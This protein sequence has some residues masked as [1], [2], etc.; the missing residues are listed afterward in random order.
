MTLRTKFILYL[1]ILHTVFVGLSLAVFFFYPVWLFFLEGLFLF[2]LLYGLRLINSFFGSL[3]LIKTGTK[4]I[5]EQDFTSRFPEVGQEEIDQLINVYNKMIDQLKNERIQLQE[6]NFF[7]DKILDAS[8]SGVLIFDFDGKISSANPSSEKI[9]Q[10][11]KQDLIGKT[12]EELNKPFCQVL[13][14]IET[15]Q[16][17]VISLAAGRRIKCQRLEFFD[18]GFARYFFLL[19]ELTEELQQSEK[20]AYEKLIRM[21]S[22][23]VNNSIAATN[24]LLHSCLNYKQQ[25]DLDDQE[26]FET[27]LTVIIS[28][29]AQLN[30]FMNSLA[31]VVRL[32]NPKLSPTNVKELLETLEILLRSECQKRSIVWHWQIIKTPRLVEMDK[33]QMQQVFVN[34]LKN[35]VEAIENNGS[36]TIKLDENDQGSFVTIIDTGKG[37]SSEVQAKL[38]TP[39]F[40]TKDNGQGIGLMLVKEILSNHHFSFSL[41]S[42]IGG[43]TQFTIFFQNN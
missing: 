15:Y 18:R 21:M 35:A 4:F 8:P 22:H 38:F 14:E 7:L 16:A 23:E 27:A 3:N 26:D 9:L 41:E 39:F 32:P 42:D 1:L 30:T 29:T 13:P 12:L 24:S 31:E 34:I 19:Q 17:R 36:I 33:I 5:A 6:Q 28:R 10:S 2:T 43:P 40:S 11:L 25:L 37:I 20:A